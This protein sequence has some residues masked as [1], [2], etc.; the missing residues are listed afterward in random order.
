MNDLVEVEIVGNDVNP[1]KVRDFFVKGKSATE[2]IEDNLSDIQDLYDKISSSD[3]TISEKINEILKIKTSML[4]PMIQLVNNPNKDSNTAIRAAQVIQLVE[5]IERSLYQKANFELSQEVDF[6]HPKIQIAFKFIY[7]V[8][9]TH[10]TDFLKEDEL[11]IY[12]QQLAMA[13]TGMEEEFNKRLKGLSANIL[14]TIENPLLKK[15]K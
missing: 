7:E 6:N 11:N 12:K 4:A 9:V 14:D 10:L 5:N 3:T 2:I 15:V 13:L 8:V 1:D